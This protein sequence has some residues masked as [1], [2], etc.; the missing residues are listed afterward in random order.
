MTDAPFTETH[1]KRLQQLKVRPSLDD[2]DERAIDAALAEIDRL[3]T[4]AEMC[5]AELNR[6][7]LKVDALIE[8]MEQAVAL[9][10][11]WHRTWH[12]VGM[13]EAR[14]AAAWRLYLTSPEM[15]AITRA[16]RPRAVK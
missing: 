6:E 14:E 11:T 16:L 15:Q 2:A 9:I 8:R 1:R 3:R 4:G 10:R 12:G 7:T 13:P 5:A